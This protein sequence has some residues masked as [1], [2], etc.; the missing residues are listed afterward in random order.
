MTLEELII[1]KK[2][3]LNQEAN[4]LEVQQKQEFSVKFLQN[5]GF[6]FLFELFLQIDKR[7][8]ERDIIRTKLLN[9]LVKI[10]LNLLSLKLTPSF[11]AAVTADHIKQLIKENLSII[12]N[13]IDS[14][15]VQQ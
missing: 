4:Q 8:L 15:N 11:K 1:A 5:G 14:L 10:L 9:I 7:K 2:D 13:F 6:Q 3:S 12:E